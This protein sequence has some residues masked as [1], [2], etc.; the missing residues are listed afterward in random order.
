MQTNLT[1]RP[2]I[3]I[4]TILL[5]VLGIIGLPTS[6][7]ELIDNVKN[8]IRLGLD[9]KGGSHL[10]ME[11]QVQDAVKGDAQQTVERL[12][13]A[14]AKQSIV[15]NS[16]EALSDPQSVDDADKVNITI[17]GVNPAKASRLPQPGSHRG[18][19]LY[20]HHAELHRLF[21]EAHAVRADRA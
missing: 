2:V 4:V 10:V 20:S 7:A 8:H 15:W 21:H 6:K 13:Q 16:A 17:K 14:A 5:C 19:H 3:I 11:V 9:L 1:T 12:Q 18:A